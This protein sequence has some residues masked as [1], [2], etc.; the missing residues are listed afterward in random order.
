[1]RVPGATGH[2]QHRLVFQFAEGVGDMQRVGHHHQT[3]LLT[4][5][6][7]HG[8]GGTATVDDD[9]RMFADTRHCS[10]GDGLLVLGDRLTEVGDQ[11]LWHGDRATIT[12]QQQTVAL[13]CRKILAN[14]NFRRFEAFCQLIHTDFALLVEQ[15][16]DIV[17]TLRCVALR[18]DLVS[19]DSKDNGSN[20]NLLAKL[21]QARNDKNIC[22]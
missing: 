2:Q 8:G 14:R 9:A 12:A 17:A 19:F 20:Q 3:G 5:F 10:T 16:K 21:R 11:F 7:D 22:G 4:K 1:M 6:R 15:G 18:H 13:E